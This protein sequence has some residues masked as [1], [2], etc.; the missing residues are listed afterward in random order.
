MARFL[1]FISRTILLVAGFGAFSAPLKI[2]IYTLTSIDATTVFWTSTSILLPVKALSGISPASR[3]PPRIRPNRQSPNAPSDEASYDGNSSD[4]TADNLKTN[5]VK[6][7]SLRHNKHEQALR[8]P[9]LL[10]GIRFSDRDD[11]HPYT[12]QALIEGF[13]LQTMTRVQASTYDAAREGTSVLA[14]SKTG[15]GKTLAF[16][17]P[18]LERLLDSDFG[19]IPGRSVGCVVLAPTRELAIQIADQA[20]LLVSYHN[21]HRQGQNELR[22]ACI[23]GKQDIL[24]RPKSLFL[25]ISW[26]C[27]FKLLRIEFEAPRLTLIPIGLNFYFSKRWCEDAKRHTTNNG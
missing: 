27:F 1:Q 3:R 21:M 23:Y 17:I 18:T 26:S 14:R 11:L 25:C 8:D 24:S 10:T 16:L 20:E 15:S 6:N 19:Y 9:S 12:K 7:E 22:V 4:S 2:G 13:C 5:R